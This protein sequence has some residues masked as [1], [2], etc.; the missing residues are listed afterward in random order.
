MEHTE[1]SLKSDRFLQDANGK[2]VRDKYG[3]AIMLP[4]R[5]VSLD[6]LIDEDWHIPTSIPTPEDVLLDTEYSE[7]EELHRCITLLTEDEQYVNKSFI[8]RG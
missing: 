6:K 4:E 5:E 8:L 1:I 7:I 2:A 3:N